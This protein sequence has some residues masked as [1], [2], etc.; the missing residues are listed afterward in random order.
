VKAKQFFMRARSAEQD[1]RRLERMIDHYSS[2]GASISSK[3]GGIGGGK[4]NN[5]SKVE[6]AA[7]GIITAE[8][9]ILS[10][11]TRYRQIVAEAENV[12]SRIPQDRFRQILTLHY[13]AGM[14]LADVSRTL[15]YKHTENLYR[16]HGWALGAAQKIIDQ[17]E[18]RENN[19]TRKM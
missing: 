7:V 12:I 4:G 8:Q 6:T 2:V 19:G 5:Q 14:T 1:I 15:N 17:Q 10:E 18:E 3:W 16:A 11:L 9:G 13:L